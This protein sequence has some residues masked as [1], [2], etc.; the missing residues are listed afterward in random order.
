MTEATG[1]T[2]AVSAE[3]PAPEGLGPASAPTPL[4]PDGTVAASRGAR[5]AWVALAVV[6]LVGGSLVAARLIQMQRAL[7]LVSQQSRD[8]GVQHQ[9]DLAQVR[10][11]EERMDAT[12]HR[13]EQLEQELTVFAGRDLS[14]DADLRRLREQSVLAEVDELL[15][16]AASQLQISHDPSAAAAAL[17][18][19]DARLARLPRAQFIG[20][21]EALARDIER[22]RK[23]P[24]PDLTGMAIR[25][26]RLVQGVDSWHLLADPTRR[27]A[28][29]PSRS[30]VEPAPAGRLNWIGREFGDTFRDLVRIRTIDSPEVL[31]M[32]A[33]QHQLVREHVRVRL[34]G[35]RQTMLLRNDALFRSDLSD[36]QAL[37]GRYFDPVD[38]LVSAALA[39]LKAMTTAAIDVPA[40]SLED[41]QAA[42]RSARPSA[43]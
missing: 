39:Q 13:T 23:S 29:A 43:P 8:L 17:G 35:A 9:R 26:D 37:I 19:A 12:S 40:P 2:A 1:E 16:L 14:G 21:R 28:A 18:T 3:P 31:L 33:D 25:L 41:S 4:P 6:A 30:K 22:L 42:L 5:W 10:E 38:P 34:L 11:L 15:T 24:T 32:P 27:L 20:L 7:Q 36:C